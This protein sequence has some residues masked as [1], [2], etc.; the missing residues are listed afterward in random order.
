MYKFNLP[1]TNKNENMELT[2]ASDPEEKAAMAK[3]IL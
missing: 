2:D 3:I 1:G